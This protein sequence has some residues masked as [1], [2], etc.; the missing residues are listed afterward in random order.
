MNKNITVSFKSRHDCDAA[1]LTLSLE[2]HQTSDSL[3]GENL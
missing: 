1:R 3:N 2:E